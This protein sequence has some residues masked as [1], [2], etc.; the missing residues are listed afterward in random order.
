MLDAPAVNAVTQSLAKMLLMSKR[1]GDLLFRLADA[2]VAEVAARGS[3]RYVLPIY[4]DLY[5][6]FIK[7]FS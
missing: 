7:T 1:F 3:V 6:R 5:R 4:F 2:S